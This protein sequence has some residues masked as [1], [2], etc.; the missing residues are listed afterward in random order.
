MPSHARRRSPLASSNGTPEA[1]TLRPGAWPAIRMRALAWACRTGRGPSGRCAVQSWQARTRASR[2]SSVS[3][4]SV[5]ISWMADSYRCA[6]SAACETGVAQTVATAQRAPRCADGVTLG[7][8]HSDSGGIR[9]PCARF[10]EKCAQHRAVA[11]RFV[12]AIAAHGEVGVLR[13]PCQ[14]RQG[15]AVVR[16][17]HLGAVLALEGSPLLGRGGGLGLLDGLGARGQVGVPDVVPVL[18]RELL[19]GHAARR[20]AHGADAGALAGYAR[21]A[22][23][24]DADCHGETSVEVHFDRSSPIA[25]YH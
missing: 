13:H 21:A 16:R 5:C 22:E 1:C 11:V 2:V 12:L 24:N 4:F 18:R 14:Q 15:V 19:L 25:R 8:A 7:G 20:A 17:G 9:Y 23:L 3:C 6:L 10:G